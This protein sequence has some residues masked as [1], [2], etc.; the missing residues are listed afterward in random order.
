VAHSFAVDGAP[1]AIGLHNISVN[2]F[3][4]MGVAIGKKHRADG[5]PIYL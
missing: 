3:S 2:A 4:K 5:A 1:L